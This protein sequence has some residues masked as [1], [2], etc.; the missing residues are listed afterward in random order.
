MILQNKEVK[1]YRATTLISILSRLA[2]EEG[3]GEHVLYRHTIKALAEML[4]YKLLLSLTS[5][6]KHL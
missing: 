3:R 2:G 1:D 5:D 4:S 6:I